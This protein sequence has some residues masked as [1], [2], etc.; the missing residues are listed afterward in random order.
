MLKKVYAVDGVWDVSDDEWP[1]KCAIKTGIGGEG[2]IYVR[3][4]TSAV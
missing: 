1:M 4:D 2:T 3:R